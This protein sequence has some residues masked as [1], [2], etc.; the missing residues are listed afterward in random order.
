MTVDYVRVYAPT[1]VGPAA[2]NRHRGSR[3]VVARLHECLGSSRQRRSLPRPGGV[4]DVPDLRANFTGSTLTLSP[5]TITDPAPYWYIGGGAPGRPGNKIMSA[6][7]YVEKTGSL[8]GKTV[9]FSGTVTANTLTSAHGTLAF[10]KDFAADYSSF[11]STTAPLVNG[12]FSISLTTAPG[13][14][15]HVQYGFETTGVNV[16]PTDA[17]PFGS[18][19]ISPF[20]AT[21]F[22]T[23]ISGF[24]FSA[25]TN[26][27]LTPTGDP[28]LDG[29]SNFEEFALNDDP[30]SASVSGKVRTRIENAN[31]GPALV[32]TLPVRA[33]PDF[34]GSPGKSATADEVI[35]HIEGSN[36]LAV[37]DQVVT[38][39]PASNEGLPPL[40]RRLE[41]P[42]FSPRWIYQ[43][44]GSTRS[45]GLPPRADDFGSATLMDQADPFLPRRLSLDFLGTRLAAGAKGF[46]AFFASISRVRFRQSRRGAFSPGSGGGAGAW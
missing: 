17:G 11:T 35:Y 20:I 27:D 8:S 9:T 26:P 6:S 7:M 23:W 1:A 32:L 13:S 42:E 39:I 3:R 40:D 36:G 43:W 45:G 25:W 22:S 37:F 28:D 30:R 21:P 44:P 34:S 15:R 16:W 2:R 29:K 24:D 14:G 38:E 4:W 33:I 31:G 19:K 41:L 18:V 10:I 12:T 5:N 46:A